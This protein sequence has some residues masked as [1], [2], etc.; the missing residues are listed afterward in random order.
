MAK[1]TKDYV[2]LYQKEDPDPPGRPLATHVEPFQIND[3]VPSEAEVDAEVR[4]LHP[5]KEGGHTHLRAE[6]F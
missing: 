3:E 1:V 5:H 4:L 2:T 6:H